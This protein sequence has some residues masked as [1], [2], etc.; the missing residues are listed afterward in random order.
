MQSVRFLCRQLSENTN[1]PLTSCSNRFTSW[2]AAQEHTEKAHHIR[3]ETITCSI[4]GEQF[5]D[6]TTGKY[7]ARQAR[8]HARQYHPEDQVDYH[9]I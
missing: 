9:I 1:R 7:V 8:E 4:C 2:L 5:T 3:L 6:E